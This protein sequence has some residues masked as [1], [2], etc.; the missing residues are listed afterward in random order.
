ME[1]VQVAGVNKI[2]RVLMMDSRSLS[3]FT[4]RCMH[5]FGCPPS[6]I[7]GENVGWLLTPA[8]TIKVQNS[9]H[10]NGPAGAISISI[11][12]TDPDELA[13][14]MGQL[15]GQLL[16]ECYEW[17]EDKKKAGGGKSKYKT[18][19]NVTFFPGCEPPEG[20][21]NIEV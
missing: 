21:D 2:L 19:G 1:E 13:E 11:F 8:D 10:E 18:E 12:R 5:A 15:V 3:V 20:D 16:P 4:E 6:P 7:D 17:V 14:V 9:T